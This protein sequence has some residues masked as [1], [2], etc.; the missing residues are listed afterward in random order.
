MGKYKIKIGI[1]GGSGLDDPDILDDRVEKKVTTKFGDPSDVLIEGKIGGQECVLLARHGRRHS[2]M[3][4]AVNFRANIWALKDAGCTHILASTATGS[5]R[6]EICPGHLV[7]LDSFIDRTTKRA[8]SFYDGTLEEGVCH[9]PM[10]PA[11]CEE[12]R[13][14]II[15][16]LTKNGVTHHSK[17]TCVS[18]EGPR[19]SSRAESN[20]FRSWGAD[21]INMTTC[22]E[23]VLAK[24]A[25]ICYAAV[26]MSTDYDCWRDHGDTVCVADVLATF[27]KNAE[28]VTALFKEAVPLIGNQGHW[29]DIIDNLRGTVEGSI[30]RPSH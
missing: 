21:V 12:T 7:V 26:A 1:I 5:L 30:M 27:K 24:E 8:Q 10:Y 14:L 19:F 16:L 2:I 23:V 3:P 22:P 28:K 15:G 13:K 11:F 4:S 29:D 20:M 18:I 6:E 25:G 17:G 9:L